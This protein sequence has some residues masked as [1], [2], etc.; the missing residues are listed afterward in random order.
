MIFKDLIKK[1]NWIDIKDAF[2][3]LYPNQQKSLDGYE[4]VLNKLKYIIPKE[5]SFEI[6]LQTIKEEGE[7]LYVHVNANDISPKSEDEYAGSWSLMGTSWNEWL[8]MPINK[9]SLEE[10]CEIDIL[11]HCLWEMTFTGFEE[12]SNQEFL[13]KLDDENE[14]YENMS[15]EEKEEKYTSFEDVKK[16]FGYDD[17]I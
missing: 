8:Y 11:V 14:K 15:S 5:N 2:I 6:N 10:F 13:D 4:L 1:Y 7:N 16:K 12:E 9:V 17:K 3:S